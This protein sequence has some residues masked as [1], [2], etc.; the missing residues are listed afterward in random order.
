VLRAAQRAASSAAARAARAPA[1]AHA[2]HARSKIDSTPSREAYLG[3]ITGQTTKKSSPSR[4]LPP[5][6]GAAAGTPCVRARR[7]GAAAR[8]HANPRS[9]RRHAAARRRGGA[10]ARRRGAGAGARWLM[11]RRDSAPAPLRATLPDKRLKRLGLGRR[12]QRRRRRRRWRR[13]ALRA[14][15]AWTAW[16][17]TT[18][19]ARAALPIGSS[20]SSLSTRRRKRWGVRDFARTRSRTW[21]A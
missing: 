3:G 16:T 18:S 20:F 12:R 19:R 8:P 14:W 10:A 2:A 21:R 11:R 5:S 1:F 6:G 7:R 13:R 17:R 4:G 15:R 9:R